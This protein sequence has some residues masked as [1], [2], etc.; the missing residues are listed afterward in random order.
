MRWLSTSLGSPGKRWLSSC[1][2]VQTQ[3]SNS[4]RKAFYDKKNTEYFYQIDIYEEDEGI[5][6]IKEVD[7][8]PFLRKEKYNIKVP[9]D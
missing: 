5:P 7:A 3:G 4:L 6:V 2:G 1:T 8:E 9:R